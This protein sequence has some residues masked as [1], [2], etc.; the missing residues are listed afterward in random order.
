MRK[1]VTSFAKHALEPLDDGHWLRASRKPST[2]ALKVPV[3]ARNG[4][5]VD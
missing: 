1:R 3:I 5:A 4:N 2:I